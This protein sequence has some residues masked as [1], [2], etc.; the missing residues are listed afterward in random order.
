MFLPATSALAAE[1]AAGWSSLTVYT[2]GKTASYNG[3]NWMAKW[4]TQNERRGSADVWSDQGAC[5]CCHLRLFRVA[6]GPQLLTAS[7]ICRAAWAG[8]RCVVS[9]TSASP[10]SH[11][12]AA[13]A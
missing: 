1:C 10:C 9:T 3:H 5:G 11:V 8:V 13:S 4:W 12:R 2:G 7:A 6:I